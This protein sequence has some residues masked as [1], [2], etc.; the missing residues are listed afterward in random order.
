MSLAFDNEGLAVHEVRDCYLCHG[1][2]ER[3]FTHLRDRLYSAPGLWD[4]VQCPVCGLAWL[5]PLP[6]IESLDRLYAEYYTHVMTDQTLGYPRRIEHIARMATHY[7]SI[8]SLGYT[9]VPLRRRERI[10]GRLTSAIGPLRDVACGGIM[11]LP[12]KP[13]GRLLDIGSGSGQFLARMRTLGWEVNGLDPDAAAVEAAEKN[14]QITSYHGTVEEAH[15]PEIRSM[16][17]R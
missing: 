14:Y 6:N 7:A 13:G 3:R 5:N 16:Q 8:L 11:W 10:A 4:I 17:S 15:F 12:A 2:G 9:Q 1:R